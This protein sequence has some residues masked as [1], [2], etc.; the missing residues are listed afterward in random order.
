MQRLVVDPLLQLALAL[1]RALHAALVD[2]RVRVRGEDLDGDDVVAR[3]RLRLGDAVGDQEV[4]ERPRRAGERRGEHVATVAVGEVRVAAAARQED[5]S[6]RGQRLQQRLLRRHERDVGEHAHLVAR[7]DAG[8]LR[9]ATARRAQQRQLGDVGVE[10]VAGGVQQLQHALGLLRRTGQ[11]ALR[12][13]QRPHAAAAV[14]AVGQ[15]AVGDDDRRGGE[16]DQP[17]RLGPLHEDHDAEE[18]QGGGRERG[19]LPEQQHGAEPLDGRRAA[20]QRHGADDQRERH[21]V[22]HQRGGQRA[23][24]PGQRE[25][26]ARSDDGV[27]HEHGDQGRERLLR[28]VE[29]RLDRRLALLSDQHD[30]GAE[31]LRPHQPG[32]RHEEEARDERHV[33]ERDRVGLAAE[34]QVDAEQLRQRE[35]GDEHPPRHVEPRVHDRQLRG[36]TAQEHGGRRRDQRDV[37]PD[38]QELALE[39]QPAGERV[40]PASLRGLGHVR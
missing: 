4:A 8:A 9:L 20:H 37:Q 32:R 38:G 10:D 39:A 11:L 23:Q 13:V 14:A 3:E 16:E 28:Q 29:G 30:A 35:G 40:P 17:G 33:A 1:Q 7:A 25:R 21:E 19:R 34:R 27:E 15:R 22:R 12:R 24:Q 26:I 18:P 2:E 31:E 5:G 6:L 36:G